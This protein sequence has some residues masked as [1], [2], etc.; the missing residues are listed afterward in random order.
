MPFLCSPSVILL[1]GILHEELL[2]NVLEM[3]CALSHFHIHPVSAQLP[4]IIH[5]CVSSP[6]PA[7]VGIW[8]HMG[9]FWEVCTLLL[10]IMKH[11]GDFPCQHLWAFL[12]FI[13]CLEFSEGEQIGCNL[14]THPVIFGCCHCEPCVPLRQCF[15]QCLLKF[16][17]LNISL[18]RC[19]G[20]ETKQPAT[21]LEVKQT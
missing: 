9:P 21:S 18:W 2:I 12:L 6:P 14:H 7:L 5:P 1:Q 11:V 13:G 8:T 10:H 15:I 20:T 3:S 4:D 19:S 17:P 16:D